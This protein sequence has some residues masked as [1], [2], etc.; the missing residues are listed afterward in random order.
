[1]R[2]IASLLNIWNKKRI[3]KATVSS[4]RQLKQNP[5][6]VT[7]TGPPQSGTK[8]IISMVKKHGINVIDIKDHSYKKFDLSQILSKVKHSSSNLTFIHTHYLMEDNNCLNNV[9]KTLLLPPEY[10]YL[11]QLNPKLGSEY[12]KMAKLCYCDLDKQQEN[13]DIILNEGQ[14]HK[15]TLYTLTSKLNS[16]V[17]LKKLKEE[18]ISVKDNKIGCFIIW[19]H[20]L[21][22]QIQITEIIKNSFNILDSKHKK[23][24]NMTNFIEKIYLQEILKIGHHITHKSRHLSKSK[25]QCSLIIVENVNSK[26][27]CHGHGPQQRICKN[28]IEH[29]KQQIR[30]KYNP[31]QPSGQRTEE[32]VIHSADDIIQVANIL[33]VFEMPPLHE[34]L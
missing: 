16:I 28:F 32:H 9:I 17:R 8:K 18:Y 3:T 13:F 31:I 23:N 21:K 34:Y 2:T 20:G 30:D 6:F 15:S 19:G 10:K 4:L 12:I 26:F 24:C 29:T 33:Q 22:N 27:K 5:I 11:K 14:G 25:G 1:M 7:I